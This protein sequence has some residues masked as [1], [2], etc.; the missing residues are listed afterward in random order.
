M[1][2]VSDPLVLSSIADGVILVAS[3]G[4]TDLDQVT[5]AVD[6]LRQVDAPLLGT[7]LNRFSAKRGGAYGY[8]YGTYQAAPQQQAQ[9]QVYATQVEGL[10]P[11][12][13]TE[14]GSSQR[15]RFV[16]R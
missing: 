6:T 12:D 2:A 3:A 7:V 9:T 13:T 1:L 10:G 8:G 4:N 16:K 15:R 5:R 14:T 11:E